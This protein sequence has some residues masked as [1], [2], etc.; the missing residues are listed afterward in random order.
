MPESKVEEQGTQHDR[1]LHPA[2]QICT[3]R[4]EASPAPAQDEGR[5]HLLWCEGI[6][7]LLEV[8]RL[9]ARWVG[10]RSFVIYLIYMAIL[11]ATYGKGS[12][13]GQ[14]TQHNYYINQLYCKLIQKV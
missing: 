11:R 6:L 5:R 12:A 1:V 13:V 7:S 8:R 9:Y 2:P 14:L 3:K 10:L 4:R